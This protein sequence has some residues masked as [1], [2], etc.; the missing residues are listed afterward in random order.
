[1]GRN[2]QLLRRCQIVF[3]LINIRSLLTKTDDVIELFHDHSFDVLCL[4]ATWHDADSV[5]IRRLRAE[6]YQVVNRPRP[7]SPVSVESLAINHGGVAVVAAPGVRLTAVDIDIQQISLER[8]SAGIVVNKS[9]CTVVV[10]YRPGSESIQPVF[11]D[12]LGD[13]LNCIATF[14]ELIYV[15]SDFNVRL[16]RAVD[17]HVSGLVE[18][19]NSYGL[20]LRVNGLTLIVLVVYWTLW[21]LAVTCRHLPLRLWMLICLTIVCLQWTVPTTRLSLYFDR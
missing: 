2:S 7:R 4:S 20:D 18:L 3:G 17:V 8:V 11:F 9:S 10:I 21:P 16:D 5:C 12:E 19:L 1:M 13:L 14:A 15:V 6:G